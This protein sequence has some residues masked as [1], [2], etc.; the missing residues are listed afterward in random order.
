MTDNFDAGAPADEIGITSE[1]LQLGVDVL[2]ERMAD[3]WLLDLERYDVVREIYLAMY[4][5]AK[6]DRIPRRT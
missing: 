2:N 5:A 1:M 3:G 6:R 4:K